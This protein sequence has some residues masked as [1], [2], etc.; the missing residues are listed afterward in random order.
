M[1]YRM[2]IG[3]WKQAKCLQE[4]V[5]EAQSMQEMEMKMGLELEH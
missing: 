2:M 4:M 1:I 3:T 5:Q